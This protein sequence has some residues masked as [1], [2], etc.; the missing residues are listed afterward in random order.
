MARKYFMIK[1]KKYKEGQKS[2]SICFQCE[3]KVATTFKVRSIPSTEN[4]F[5]ILNLLVGACD[6]CNSTISIPQQSVDQIKQSKKI[7]KTIKKTK[8]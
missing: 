7:Y 8:I 5:K 3:K 1:K 4:N 6:N 2:K